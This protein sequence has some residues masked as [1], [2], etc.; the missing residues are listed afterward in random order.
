M[1]DIY[2]CGNAPDYGEPW[3]GGRANVLG[4]L[5][6]GTIYYLPGAGGWGTNFGGRPIALW[7]R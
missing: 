6:R 5:D 2:F 3:L 1:Q 4:G 7:K